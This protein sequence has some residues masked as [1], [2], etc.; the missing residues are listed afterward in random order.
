M[1]LG[2]G[3]SAWMAPTSL[4]WEPEPVYETVSLSLETCFFFERRGRGR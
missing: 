1:A 4:V 3:A 2:Q